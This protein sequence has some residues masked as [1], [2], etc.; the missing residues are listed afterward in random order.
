MGEVISFKSGAP[1]LTPEILGADSAVLTIKEFRSN[2]KTRI[3]DA[4]VIVFEEFPEHG[5]YVNTTSLK[6]IVAVYG[7]DTGRW[8]KKALVPVEVRNSSV[9]G[10]SKSTKTLWA[11]GAQLNE[12]F[13]RAEW[14]KAVRSAKKLARSAK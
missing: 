8:P 4:N 14:D 7:A 3:G 12:P 1:K 6:A 9:V 13:N 10:S 5:W 2:Q 11:V